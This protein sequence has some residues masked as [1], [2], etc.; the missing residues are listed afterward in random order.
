M[1]ILKNKQVFFLRNK[2]LRL[3][4]LL[5]VL[6]GLLIPTNL[7]GNFTKNSTARAVGD[8]T[9]DWG[10]GI[11]EGDPIF[12][13]NN[14]MPGDTESRTV[15][16]EN[17]AS[18]NRP[19]AVRGIKTAETGNL[20][21]VLSMI[22]SENGTDLYG[23]ASPTGP[24][25]LAE[26]FDESGG[27]DGIPL[28]MLGPGEDT[29]YTFEVGFDENAGNEFQG[30]SVVFDLKIGIAIQVPEECRDIQFNGNP[31]LGTENSD[32][33]NG[34]NGNDLIFA[35][36]GN[37]VVNAS[38]GNDCVVGGPGDDIVHGSNGNDLLFGNEGD[39]RIDGSNGNDLIFGGDGNDII[40]GSNGNDMIEGGE[41]NDKIEGGN[42]DDNIDG[43]GGNDQIDAGNG[44]DIVNAGG[45]NDVIDGGNGND[46]INGEGGNDTLI[47]R[48]GNDFLLGGP[49][50][51]SANGG[52]GS[53]TCD[54][55]T[56]INCEL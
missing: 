48:N 21:T 2:P 15:H 39:D 46:Q 34:T 56:E 32:V 42:G 44:N 37:D 29:D 18:G 7:L 45:G 51:D 23:G 22:I 33:I 14:I 6:S 47:G 55:E 11:N 4:F 54:A 19:V 5:I 30:K 1:K 12:V 35:F 20:S 9:V 25:T 38:N 16:V 52:L 27:P 26:F 40:N 31:I 50:T 41:G 53:D 28:S 8:L 13:V 36:E 43:G 10:P 49:D 3:L 24:K 17:G